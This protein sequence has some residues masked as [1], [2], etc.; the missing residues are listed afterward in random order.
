MD[1]L[2]WVHN[3]ADTYFG[4]ANLDGEFNTSDLVAVFEAG[5]YEDGIAGNSGWGTGDWN[6]DAEFSTSDL[7]LAFQDG[8]YE[9][10]PRG[11]VSSVPE[12]NA[13]CL[14]LLG[15]TSLKHERRRRR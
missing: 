4:D 10:G 12:P 5:H 9:Q 3:L 7:V 13:L 1:R 14:L 15:A 2:Y 11:A 6:G 8:G